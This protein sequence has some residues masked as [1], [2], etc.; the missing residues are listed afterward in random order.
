MAPTNRHEELASKWIN[1]TITPE[2]KLEFSAWYND[3]PDDRTSLSESFADDEEQLKARI[4][5]NVRK[6]MGKKRFQLRRA[7]AVAA[8]IALVATAGILLW[9]AQTDEQLR[10]LPAAQQDVKPGGNRATL[11]LT[12]GRV[13]DLSSEKGGIII[14]DG[15]TYEDGS[16]VA[17]T[18]E[19]LEIATPKGGQYQLTLPDGTRV[20]LNSATVL[21]YPATFKK[22]RRVVELVAGEAYFEVSPQPATDGS[23]SKRPFIVRTRQQEVEVLGT[24]FNINAYEDE[25]GI[26]TTLV[27]GAVNVRHPGVSNDH[28]TRLAPGEQAQLA[29]NSIIVSKIN[30]EEFTAWKDGYFYFNDADVYTV[31]KQLERW[32]DIDVIYK[33]TTSDDL[34][35]GKIPRSVNLT[36]ALNVLRTAGV[37]FEIEGRTLT[38]LPNK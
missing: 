10:H 19:P 31:L 7:I 8:A 22:E 38:V 4:L 29:G 11:T 36:V 37:S 2:E 18:H 20:W 5:A 14:G 23:G 24:Q 32:Y 26:T 35:V 6:G 27:E 25:A 21:K 34:F 9:Q 17:A 28:I 3:Y 13:I 15:I 1:G 12:D 16:L 30:T 33:I